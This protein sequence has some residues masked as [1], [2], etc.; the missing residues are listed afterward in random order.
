MNRMRRTCGLLDSVVRGEEGTATDCDRACDPGPTVSGYSTL[1]ALGLRLL[2]SLR[3][4]QPSRCNSLVLR[5]HS[6][7]EWGGNRATHGK[8]ASSL[9]CTVR[10]TH[11][12]IFLRPGM[13]MSVSRTHQD[14]PCHASMSSGSNC[15]TLNTAR[16]PIRQPGCAMFSIGL[17]EVLTVHC[18]HLQS[19]SLVRKASRNGA[20]LQRQGGEFSCPR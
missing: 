6:M 7:R 18:G 12:H 10:T 16:V 2:L 4:L 3:S 8:I 19:R 17:L 9:P 14:K 20:C 1:I 15:N 5:R 11:Q 13:L